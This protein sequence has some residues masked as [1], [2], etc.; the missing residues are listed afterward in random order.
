M[1]QDTQWNDLDYMKNGNDFT[2]D[3]NRFEGLPGFVD[4]L[5]NVNTQ[6]YN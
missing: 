5:H 2:Y 3:E 4:L 1:F 6:P